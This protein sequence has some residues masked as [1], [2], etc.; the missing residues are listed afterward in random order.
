M[1]PAT[2]NSPRLRIAFVADDL[3]PG[4]GGQAVS[5]EGHIGAL[6]ERGHEV[7]AL[8]GAERSPTEPPGVVTQRLPVWRPPKK[9]IH[10]AFPVWQK[11]RAFVGWA[12]VVHIN[13]PT[14]LALGVLRAARR[15]NVP[16]VLGFHA[17]EESMIMHTGELVLPLLRAWYRF[18]YGQPD[19]LVAPTPFAARLASRYTRRPVH[20]VSNGIS[21]PKTSA[22]DL[23]RAAEFKESLLSGKRFLISHVGRLSHEKRPYGLLELM[24][25]LHALRQDVRLVVAGDGPLRP[26]LERRAIRLG[27]ADVVRFLGYVPEDLKQD[28][29]L[30]GDLFLMPSPTELQSIATL[31]AMAQG[32][33]VLAAS[34]ETSAVPELVGGAGICYDPNRMSGA[35]SD[36]SRLLD[37]PQE[38]RVLGEDAARVAKGHDIRQSARLLEEVYTS[39][40]EDRTR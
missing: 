15:G 37:A 25:A 35:A 1:E 34:Y 18:I 7:R 20:V 23:E 3:Y 12:D 8:A 19:A 22:A 24:S 36:I 14:P 11:V 28:L 13:T 21:L 6:L 29:L 26:A 40:I 17:Q 31:E 32:C 5:T 10:Y 30:A 2:R 9:Q 38:L 39:L 4:Y 27:L 16:G 33:A